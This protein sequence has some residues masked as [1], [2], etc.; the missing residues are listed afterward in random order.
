MTRYRYQVRDRTL[1]DKRSFTKI[2][3]KI[4][5]QPE[6]VIFLTKSGEEARAAKEAGI[7]P[8]LVLTHRTN[9]EK[10]DEVDKQFQRIRS[11]NELE[12]E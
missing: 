7:T 12:F 5:E 1:T 4:G 6:N 11:F 9:I 10:L 8:V 2:L 3:A